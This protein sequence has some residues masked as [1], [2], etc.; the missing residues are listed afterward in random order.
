MNISM[1]YDKNMPLFGIKGEESMDE[2]KH[3]P[4]EEYTGYRDK[5]LHDIKLHNTCPHCGYQNGWIRTHLDPV[6]KE[7]V[8]ERGYFWVSPVKMERR[9]GT[10]ESVLLGCPV[11]SKTFIEERY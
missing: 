3:S 6:G 7:V 11:C 5:C 2:L 9:H 8:G 10:A 1:K 4:W